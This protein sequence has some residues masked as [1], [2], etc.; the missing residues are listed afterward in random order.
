MWGGD[1]WDVAE[2]GPSNFDRTIRGASFKIEA[3]AG[4]VKLTSISDYLDMEKTYDE[5]TDAGPYDAIEYHDMNHLSQVTQ[6]FRASGDVA[7]NDWQAGAFYMHLNG[8]YRAPFPF[9]DSDYFP[10]ATYQQSTVSS[11]LFGQDEFKFADQ[12]SLIGGARIWRDERV[13]D[14]HIAD[15][16]GVS[17]DYNPTLYPNLA[18]RTFK[19]YSAKLEL[20]RKFTDNT[21]TYVSWNRGTKSGGYT[22]SSATPANTPQAIQ[23]FVNGIAYNPEILTDYEAGVKTVV[24]GGTTTINADAFYYD[25]KDYQGYIQFTNIETIVNL[26]AKS[27]GVELEIT[28]HPVQSLTMSTGISTLRTRVDD[29]TLEDGTMTSSQLP[30]A[31]HWSGHAQVRYEVPVPLGMTAAQLTETYTGHLCF[32]VLCPQ[33]DEEGGHAVTDARVSF[34][35][36][37]GNWD[38]AFVVKNLTN[39]EYRIFEADQSYAGILNSVYAPPRWYTVTFSM[40]FGATQH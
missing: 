37:E 24:F 35:P 20:D 39:R 7:S 25:Y 36:N 19:N 40:R 4:P 15:N 26:P 9:P 3:D 33:V 30:Q 16:F 23:G 27:H 18:D 6:E 8:H 5:D 29:V 38:V 10:L 1:P 12:W 31:P 21:L 11:A 22:V 14:Y 32:T 2:T 17:I 28:S 13:L 34:R